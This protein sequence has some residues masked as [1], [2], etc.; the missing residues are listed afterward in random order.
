MLAFSPIVL[1][2]NSC[3]SKIEVPLLLNLAAIATAPDQLHPLI[4]FSNI[5][6]IESMRSSLILF[7]GLFLS[8]PLFGQSGYLQGTPKLAYWQVGKK[9]EVVIILH[10]GPCVEHSYLRPELDRLQEH[11]RLI[12][13]DQRGCG[14]SEQADR[15]FWQDQVADLK[16]MIRKHGRGK[17]VFLAGSSWG[18]LLAL[19]YTYEHPEDVKGLI[20]SGLVNWMGK[21]LDPAQTLGMVANMPPGLPKMK[22]RT[23]NL[24]EQRLTEEYYDGTLVKKWVTVEKPV[25]QNHGDMSHQPVSSMQTAPAFEKLRSIKTPA[26]IFNGA[27]DCKYYRAVN[28]YLEVLPHAEIV[29]FERAC[30]DPWFSDP[31]QFS[32]RCGEFINEIRQELP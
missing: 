19:L 9:K 5:K 1:P 21:A 22:L 7:A 23:H 17:K 3:S 20:L 24:R 2:L 31:E 25:T 10:G 16:R 8:L 26:L 32:A 15:Y 27:E 4:Q 11:A 18:S 30:H 28:R 14:L 6:I 13:F 12:Y 29:Y